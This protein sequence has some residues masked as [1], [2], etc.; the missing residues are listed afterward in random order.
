MHLFCGSVCG[1]W[2]HLEEREHAMEEVTGE[3]PGKA[4]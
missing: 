1:S 4:A 2:G 3:K